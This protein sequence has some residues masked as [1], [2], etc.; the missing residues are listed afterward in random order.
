MP[1]YLGFNFNISLDWTLF[2]L[3]EF[4]TYNHLIIPLSIIT[5]SGYYFASAKHCQ[6]YQLQYV[7]MSSS[8]PL[9]LHCQTGWQSSS[10]S[11]TSTCNHPVIRQLPDD[12]RVSI[13]QL[14]VTSPCR[15]SHLSTSDRTCIFISLSALAHSSTHVPWS[16]ASMP[17][18][19]PGPSVHPLWDAWITARLFLH[20]STVRTTVYSK[21]VWIGKCHSCNVRNLFVSP[22]C[23]FWPTRTIIL[24][25]LQTFLRRSLASVRPS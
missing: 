9:S 6:C 13:T 24:Y 8:Y 5:Q 2:V 4:A 17:M 25:F 19:H 18:H 3:C 20:P 21:V 10:A 15:P 22:L 12:G 1:V 23:C 14:S 11:P 7:S 16:H